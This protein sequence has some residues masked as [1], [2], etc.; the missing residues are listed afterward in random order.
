MTGRRG[1]MFRTQPTNMLHLK[2][3]SEGSY[4]RLLQ[5]LR[6][7][8]PHFQGKE[9]LVICRRTQRIGREGKKVTE[10]EQPV[11]RLSLRSLGCDVVMLVAHNCEG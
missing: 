11:T 5:R 3:K 6:G 2:L 9:S 7:V 10:L 1:L 8:M 4:R